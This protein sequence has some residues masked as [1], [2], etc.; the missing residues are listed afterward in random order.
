MDFLVCNDEA[1]RTNSA[2]SLA[3]PFKESLCT[4]DLSP[5]LSLSRGLDRGLDSLE[6][7]IGESGRRDVEMGAGGTGL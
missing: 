5:S 6:D 2:T 7:I 4:L 3:L 1:R